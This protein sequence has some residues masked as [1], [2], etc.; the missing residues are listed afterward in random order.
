MRCRFRGWWVA[1]GV[2]YAAFELVLARRQAGASM[3][4]ISRD[5]A[6]IASARPSA[7]PCRPSLCMLSV[8]QLAQLAGALP[9]EEADRSPQR[10][11]GRAVHGPADQQRV[12]SGEARDVVADRPDHR[13]AER[14]VLQLDP[15]CGHDLHDAEQSELRRRDP[16]GDVALFVGQVPALCV[17][18]G[19]APAAGELPVVVHPGGDQLKVG[20]AEHEVVV[21]GGIS[22]SASFIA[23]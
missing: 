13:A 22:A 8:E 3:T 19:S 1:L 11:G 6:C 4:V 2:R 18:L 20:V 16:A 14:K 5:A 12:G 17:A 7:W 21:A 15:P 9:G 23:S 10:G